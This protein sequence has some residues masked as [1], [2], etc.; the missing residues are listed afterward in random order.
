MIYY[1]GFHGPEIGGGGSHTRTL[2]KNI[3]TPE[4]WPI[5]GYFCLLWAGPA[6]QRCTPVYL[7]IEDFRPKFQ[8][9]LFFSG[10]KIGMGRFLPPEDSPK[11]SE[12]LEFGLFWS[13]FVCSGVVQQ[14]SAAH[15]CTCIV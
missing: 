15:R 3:S 10:P 9:S 6:E 2:S 7:P 12:T 5:L 1:F 8:F 4:I 13:I 14:N 11:P